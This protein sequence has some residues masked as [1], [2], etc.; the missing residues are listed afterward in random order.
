MCW[1]QKA[2]CGAVEHWPRVVAADVS[3]QTAAGYHTD[4]RTH[5]LH[6]SHKREGNAA[7]IGAG[8]HTATRLRVGGNAEGVVGG[9]GGEPGP[10]VSQYSSRA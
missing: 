9:A 1:P 8:T 7:S 2:V 10:S 4:A 6:N 3:S 5:L